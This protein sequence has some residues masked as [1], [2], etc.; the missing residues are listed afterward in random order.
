MDKD[1]GLAR[2]PHSVP[3]VVSPRTKV[4][5][6]LPLSVIRTGE[7]AAMRP[8]DWISVAGVAVSAVGFTVVARRL[9]RIADAL[10]AG[11]AG[12]GANQ[13]A[14]SLAGGSWSP[15]QALSQD[16]AGP[17][18]PGELPEKDLVAGSR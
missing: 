9:A 13:E 17:G 12:R 4:T 18:G 7:S 6:A 8:R 2:H 15:A 3:R 1:T 11:Q 14:A 5:V 10:E 16:R